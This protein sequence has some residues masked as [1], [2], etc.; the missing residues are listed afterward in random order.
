MKGF[1]SLGGVWVRPRYVIAVSRPENSLESEAR[2]HL[3][4]GESID[5]A[6]SQRLAMEAIEKVLG[7]EPQV[8][9]T[10]EGE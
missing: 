5:I 7:R 2:L 3:L 9:D 1:I 8:D 6:V 10:E 4:S